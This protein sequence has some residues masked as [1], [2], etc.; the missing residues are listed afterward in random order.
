MSAAGPALAPISPYRD[1]GGLNGAVKILSLKR[2]DRD[3]TERLTAATVKTPTYFCFANWI[4]GGFQVPSP[5]GR[6]EGGSVF[7]QYRR[8]TR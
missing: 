6:M 3:S 7:G 5:G 8:M 1:P 2:D 4:P